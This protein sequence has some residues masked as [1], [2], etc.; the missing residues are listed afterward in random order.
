M[1]YYTCVL[2]S[3]RLSEICHWKILLLEAGGEETQIADVPAYLT[4]AQSAT[5][6][7]LW[8]YWT[9]P[10]PRTCGGA[11]CFWRGGKVLGGTSTINTLQYARGFKQDYDNWHSLGNYGWNWSSVLY[12]FK[13][14][15]NNLDP[16]YAEDIKYHSIGGY[17]DV[18]TFPYQ[19]KN[20]YSVLRAY[21]ELGYNNTDYNGPHSTG[22]FLLQGTAR[23]GIRQSTNNAFLKTV[24]RHR[25]NLHIVTGIRVTKLIIDDSKR[26]TGVEY[27]MDSDRAQRGKVFADKEVILSAGALASPQILM[28]SGI[29]PQETLNSLGIKVI[30][31]CKVGYNLMNHPISIGVT[32]NL[33]RSST[34]P[35][36]KE[37]W[38]SDIRQ[39]EK[40]HDGPLSAAGILQLSGYIPSSDATDDYPDLKFEFAFSGAG[41]DIADLPASYYSR[42]TVLPSYVRPKS[43]G[44]FTIKSTDPF[45]PPLVYPKLLENPADRKPL[46]EGNLFALK[47][48]NTKAFKESGFVL[49]TTKIEGCESETFGTYQYF[50]CV[51]DKYVG[52]A[53]HIVGTCRMGNSSD[54]QAVVDPELR[55]YGVRNLR[56][57]DASIMPVI[58]SAN[59]NAPTIMIGEKASDLIKTAHKLTI[60]QLL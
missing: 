59:T 3:N 17:Q 30:K 1:T 58:P 55:V 16:I 53:R 8:P 33:T 52:A 34:V 54:P 12:Y 21:R 19:D 47:L 20:I 51:L 31:N 13:K 23:D 57:V 14:S 22:I 28:L 4:Y 37:E 9:Q 44:F 27:V 40:T 7:I 6:P 29:G 10:E 36:S 43:R 38:L 56:V 60:R 35:R 26:V 24:R 5:S 15:E 32:V 2:F 39:Y 48:A 25:K 45:D 18:Q 46:I 41:N 50:N 42:I 11:P 49:D